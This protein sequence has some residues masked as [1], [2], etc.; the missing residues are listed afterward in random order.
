MGSNEFKFIYKY[1]KHRSQEIDPD[2][3]LAFINYA[4]DM[5]IKDIQ[6]RSLEQSLNEL[7][8]TF[9]MITLQNQDFASNFTYDF[10]DFTR[11]IASLDRV[12]ELIEV[13][14]GGTS[15]SGTNGMGGSQKGYMPSKG[16][17]GAASAN[18]HPGQLAAESS[19]VNQASI[20]RAL[21][22]TGTDEG[23]AVAKLLKRGNVKL[24]IEETHPKGWGGQYKFGDDTVSI[25]TDV[26]SNPQRAAGYT[27]HEVKHYLQGIDSSSYRRI[28]EFETFTWQRTVD[29]SF[30][31]RDS[32]EI[33]NFI[34]TNDAYKYV[35]K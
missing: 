16:I 24:S 31:L 29:K 9:G 6:R 33:W 27:A 34:N 25:Y 7:V 15:I 5:G 10:M 32:S 14:S 3:L 23:Q 20:M 28:Y 30:G 17:G 18:I 22:Q 4:V 2:A 35:R 11:G 19:E 1:W 13:G 8:G 26:A 21:R 12:S